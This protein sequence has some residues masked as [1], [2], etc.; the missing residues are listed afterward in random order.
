MKLLART[1]A[2]VLTLT[3]CTSGPSPAPTA[4]ALSRPT[5][6]QNPPAQAAMHVYSLSGSIT[7]FQP[8]PVVSY[9]T[10]YVSAVQSPATNIISPRPVQ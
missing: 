6:T 5:P 1:V 2:A 9:G 4:A 8:S 3:G 7:S 10:S